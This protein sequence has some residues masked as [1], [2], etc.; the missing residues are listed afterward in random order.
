MLA[1]LHIYLLVNDVCF[2]H[3]NI[4]FHTYAS[5]EQKELAVNQAICYLSFPPYVYVVTITFSDFSLK[6]YLFVSDE[7]QNSC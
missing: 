2:G 6:I 1:I 4:H 3:Q 5:L 7:G